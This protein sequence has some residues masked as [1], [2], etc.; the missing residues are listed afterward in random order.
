MA[1][2]KG[3]KFKVRGRGLVPFDMLRYDH[4]YPASSQDAAE[5]DVGDSIEDR[6][7]ERT[8]ELRSQMMLN[9]QVIV[10]AHSAGK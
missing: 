6:R 2:T 4:C 3:C 10:G 5:M 8:I 9:P 7:K 1:I